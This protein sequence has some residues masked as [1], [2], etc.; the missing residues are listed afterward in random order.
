MIDTITAADAIERYCEIRLRLP[1]AT[2]PNKSVYVSNLDD[3][4]NEFDLFV[5]DGFGVLN[6]GASP[7][8]GA[9]ARIKSLRA[10]GATVVVLTNGAT[11]PTA[12]T[13]AKYDGWGM[14]FDEIS[15]ISSRDAL[16]HGLQ[17]QGREALKWGVAAT[18]FA[19]IDQLPGHCHLLEDNDDAYA[20]SD[21]FILLSAMDWTNGRQQK[22]LN[23]LRQRPRPVLVGNPD[24]V[25]PHPE[26]L[27]L[28]PGWYAHLLADELQ[29]EALTSPVEPIFFG[30]PFTNAFDAVTRR[31]PD[32][33]PSRIAMVGDSPHTDILGGAAAGWRTVLIQQHGLCKFHDLETVFEQSGIRP[34]FVAVTT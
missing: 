26:G 32:Y 23:A 2:H 18:A 11:S 29:K 25:A 33:E 19:A 21:G 8:P 22:L 16:I 7:V 12:K 13:V 5:L 24:L 17:Q 15:V 1:V 34:D 9:A 4:V 3:L 31:F 30:K 10:A 6:V 14:A 20:Q 27:S 28:E